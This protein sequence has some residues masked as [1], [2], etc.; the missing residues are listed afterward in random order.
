MLLVGEAFFEW[1]AGMRYAIDWTAL[2]NHNNNRK[3]KCLCRMPKSILRYKIRQLESEWVASHLLSGERAVLRT[4]NPTAAWFARF[5]DEYGLSF[6]QANR[7]FEVSRAV[8]KRRHE[9]GWLNC[10]RVRW[11]D[12]NFVGYDPVQ[13]NLDHDIGLK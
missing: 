8:R 9:I 2:A 5:E 7:R 11:L 12:Q 10:F 13:K 1:W 4:V 3:R 6:R